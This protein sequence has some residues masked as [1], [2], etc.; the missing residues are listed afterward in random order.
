[1]K[2]SL[3]VTV[4]EEETERSKI[5]IF[6]LESPSPGKREPHY[7]FPSLQLSSISDR[8]QIDSLREM[9]SILPK[10]FGASEIFIQNGGVNE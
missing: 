7:N 8:N 10:I 1:M 9:Q 6:Y 2:S 4:F 5:N 3:D